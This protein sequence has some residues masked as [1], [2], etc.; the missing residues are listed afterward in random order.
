MNQRPQNTNEKNYVPRLPPYQQGENCVVFLSR[1]SDSLIASEIP[2]Q[3]WVMRLRDILTGK[4]LRTFQDIP[5]NY[6]LSYATGRN[7]LLATQNLTSEHYRKEFNKLD[8]D[9]EQSYT[10]YFFYSEDNFK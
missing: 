5:D 10:D 9:G 8:P 4:V 1:F 6:K 7:R 3:Q 2:P